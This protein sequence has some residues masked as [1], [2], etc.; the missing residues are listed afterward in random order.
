MTSYQRQLQI[1]KNR[2]YY[3]SPFSMKK[4]LIRLCLLDEHTKI[5]LRYNIVPTKNGNELQLNKLKSRKIKI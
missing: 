1:G 5:I 2:T 3:I 4:G